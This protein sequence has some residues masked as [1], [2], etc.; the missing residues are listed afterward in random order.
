MA[1]AVD[2]IQVS[3]QTPPRKEAFREDP[4]YLKQHPSH[5]PLSLILPFVNVIYT[6]L[7]N[8]T[9]HVH[10]FISMLCIFTKM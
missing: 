10:L 7:C 9:L 6:S 1:L 8:F 4:I 5:D 2:F 3:A